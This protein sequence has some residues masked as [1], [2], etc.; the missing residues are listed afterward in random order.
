MDNSIVGIRYIGKKDRQEDTVCKTG[1]VWLPGQVHN[2]GAKLAKALLVHT[3]SFEPAKVSLDGGTFLSQG[4]PGQKS[5]DVAAFVNLTAM[6]SEQ[7][8]LFSKREFG[9]TVHI[10][11]KDEAQVR[12]EVH[13]L[14]TNH[15]LDTE[16]ER[17]QEVV[18]DGKRMVPFMATPEEYA[19]LMDGS[20][21]LAI[22]P[23]EL[24]QAPEGE[25]PPPVENEG[26]QRGA[27]DNAAMPLT[28]LL[29][30][31]GKKD[32]IA[33][34]KQEGVAI[35]NTMSEEKL[36]DKIF[37]ELSARSEQKAA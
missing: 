35:S 26:E 19:A 17:K 14:M 10:D 5:A 31:L 36:R 28:D 4:K 30:S 25:V 7:M 8:A 20:V 24:M 3:D 11:G 29:A 37:A 21:V 33:F 12:R 34:A 18:S 1:A 32:L 9:R 23:A 2:F 6:D 16:A 22:V 15:N 27:S 13:A